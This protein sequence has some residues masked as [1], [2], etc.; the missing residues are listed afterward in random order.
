MAE[1][2]DAGNQGGAAQA[3]VHGQADYPVGQHL[4]LVPAVLLRVERKLITLHDCLLP[5]SSMA[6]G[7]RTA[8]L[9]RWPAP[10]DE[11]PFPT[12]P[13]GRNQEGP[14]PVVHLQPRGGA[15]DEHSCLPAPSQRRRQRHPPAAEK[16]LRDGRPGGGPGRLYRRPPLARFPVFPAAGHGP[17]P[18]TLRGRA[19][20]PRRFSP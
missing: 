6:L 9:C 4:A 16:P 19:H 10:A 8:P 17:G 14:S 20:H 11:A 12:P 15:P 3:H 1:P 13:A 18:A 5:C 2:L 7:P